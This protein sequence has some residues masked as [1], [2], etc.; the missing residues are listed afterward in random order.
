MHNIN[1]L[2]NFR[3]QSSLV[4]EQ[5]LL[6]FHKKIIVHILSIRNNFKEIIE[7]NY[8]IQIHNHVFFNNIKANN[9]WKGSLDKS[10]TFD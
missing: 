1:I 5:L 4:A 9:N 6:I 10:F 3:Y 8:E 2:I 7:R